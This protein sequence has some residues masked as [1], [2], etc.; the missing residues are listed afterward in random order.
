MSKNINCNTIVITLK[1][2]EKTK[3]ENNENNYPNVCELNAFN[4]LFS[5]KKERN[6]KILPFEVF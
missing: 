3:P 4:F 1:V 2:F 5:L 6:Y